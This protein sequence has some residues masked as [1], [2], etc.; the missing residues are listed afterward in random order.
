[1]IEFKG[2]AKQ[3]LYGKRLFGAFDFTIRDGEIIAVVG[4]SGSGK[5]SFVKAMSGVEE[6]E[7]DVIK[8]GKSFVPK[9]DDTVFLFDDGALFKFRSVRYN[10]SYPLR[11]RKHAKSEI[12][13]KVLEVADKLGIESI[14]DKKVCKISPKEKRL[15]SVARLLIRDAKY[16]VIDDFSSWTGNESERKALWDQF[17]KLLKVFKRKQ[18]TVIYTTR[19]PDEIMGIADKLV[20]LHDGEIKQVGMFRDILATPASIWAAQAV[21]PFYRFMKVKMEEID[22]KLVI[23]SDELLCGELDAESVRDRLISNEY[24]GK[25]VYIGLSGKPEKIQTLDG[26]TI[27]DAN[28]ENSIIR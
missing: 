17:R 1:M 2:F 22:G 18:K 5:T 15:V 3:Y 26:C 10:I 13:R 27:Y 24:I 12:E 4:D 8:D 25:D 20:I 16:I 14:L 23:T 11:I 19:Y 6:R 9:C 21:D 28:N 7:G